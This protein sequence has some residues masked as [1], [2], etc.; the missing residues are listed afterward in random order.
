M[1]HGTRPSDELADQIQIKPL[2][3]C[4]N[5]CF[6]KPI[7]Q[8]PRHHDSF[9]AC[10]DMRADQT[11]KEA[12]RWFH[13][14]L[15]L[16]SHARKQMAIGRLGHQPEMSEGKPPAQRSSDEHPSHLL[17]ILY[18]TVAMRRLAEVVTSLPVSLTRAP[19]LIGTTDAVRTY[20]AGGP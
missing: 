6:N 14:P 20:C 16:S 15:R 3:F 4:R 13:C 2:C 12:S 11:R 1:K 10:V 17:I 19:I 18:P 7:Y 8:V 9:R 5:C